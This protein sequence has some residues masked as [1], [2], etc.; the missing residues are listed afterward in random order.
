MGRMVR[1]KKSDV[2]LPVSG[3][4]PVPALVNRR[5]VGRG[6]VPWAGTVPC[7]YLH[8]NSGSRFSMNALKPSFESSV[9]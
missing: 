9:A 6:G 4:G 2:L 3:P 5:C 1:L 8:L 7:P